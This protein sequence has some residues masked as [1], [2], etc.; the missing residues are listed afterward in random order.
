MGK[1]DSTKTRVTPL[2]DYLGEDV[3][4]INRFLNLFKTKVEIK[5]KIIEICYGK[6]T[7][8]HKGE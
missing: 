5:D 1:D 2:M 6:E 7:D 4:K 8:G 3:T